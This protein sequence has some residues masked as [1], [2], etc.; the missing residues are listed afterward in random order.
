MKSLVLFTFLFNISIAFGQN[1]NALMHYQKTCKECLLLP[2]EAYR[3]NLFIIP[4]PD[5]VYSGGRVTVKKIAEKTFSASKVSLMFNATSITTSTFYIKGKKNIL[6]FEN[7]AK[8]KITKS[9]DGNS[10]IYVINGQQV[11]YTLVKKKRKY[12][13][14]I[15]LV[16]Q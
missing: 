8:T 12:Y 4:V 1:P 11:Y 9:A 3:S 6:N 13:A 7:W 15:E 10:S 16:N 14:S 2:G 5:S